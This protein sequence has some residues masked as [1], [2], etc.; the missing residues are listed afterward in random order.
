MQF[1]LNLLIAG[2]ALCGLLLA[3]YIRTTKKAP[4]TLVCPLEGSC[5]EVVSSSYSKLIGLPVE[6]MGI[7]YYLLTLIA[8]LGFAFF[9]NSLPFYSS[10]IMLGVGF[11]AFLFSFYLTVIQSFFL[12]HWCTWC[13]FSAG[14]STIIFIL[15]L[16]ISRQ[17]DLDL[18][19]T[20]LHST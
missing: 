8:Y 19:T 10:Y 18:V 15:A 4:G 1:I 12:K 20:L 6:N 17:N 7:L 16:Y 9:P 11:T 5:E 3:N 2:L 14:I 13:L